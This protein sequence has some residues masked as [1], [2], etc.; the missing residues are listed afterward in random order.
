MCDNSHGGIVQ[1]PDPVECPLC[2]VDKYFIEPIPGQEGGRRKYPSCACFVFNV[3]KEALSDAGFGDSYNPKSAPLTGVQYA[4]VHCVLIIQ[5]LYVPSHE[6]NGT[7]ALW[8]TIGFGKAMGDNPN[9][10]SGV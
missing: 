8:F 9:R 7:T 4:S 1:V 3:S 2:L 10:K 6:S 5:S